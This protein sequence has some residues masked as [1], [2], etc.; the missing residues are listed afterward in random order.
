MH[1]L[2]ETVSLPPPKLLILWATLLTLFAGGAFW[3][4]DPHDLNVEK[5]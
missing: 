5:P 3:Y 2:A 1:L 4:P